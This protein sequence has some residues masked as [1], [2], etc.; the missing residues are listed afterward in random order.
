MLLDYESVAKFV[1]R[2]TKPI[3]L[4][5]EHSNYL[6]LGNPKKSINLYIS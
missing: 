3:K 4:Y 5:K 2:F 1:L 6:Q